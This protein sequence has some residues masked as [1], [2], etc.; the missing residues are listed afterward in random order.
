MKLYKKEDEKIKVYSFIP[1]NVDLVQYKK[2]EMKNI[3]VEEQVCKAVTRI[4]HYGYPVFEEHEDEFDTFIFNMN[5]VNGIYHKLLNEENAYERN[6]YLDEYYNGKYIEGRAAKVMDLNK[7]KYF[8]LRQIAYKHVLYDKNVN[9]GIIQIPESLYLLHL[10][11]TGK[12]SLLGDKDVS[13]Q[14]KLFRFYFE[15]DIDM[16]T[17]GKMTDNGMAPHCMSRVL[18]KVENDKNIFNKL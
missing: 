17:I 10:I 6:C 2:E 18:K 7:M 3:P 8:L 11:E 15:H 1:D 13:E 5:D 9:M 12:F 16:D 4:G 14:L